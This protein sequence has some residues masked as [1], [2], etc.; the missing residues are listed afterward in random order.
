MIEDQCDPVETYHG[1]F[2]GSGEI[3]NPD[4]DQNTSDDIHQNINGEIHVFLFIHDN[5]SYANTWNEGNI[6]RYI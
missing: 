6:P 3:I 1:K 4:C 5:S 2:G